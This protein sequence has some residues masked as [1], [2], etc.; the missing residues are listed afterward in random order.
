MGRA[1][2]GGYHGRSP[3][4]KRRPRIGMMPPG[5]RKQIDDSLDK[6]FKTKPLKKP[7]FNPFR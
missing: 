7:L 4:K 1:S 5:R 3:Y 2:P 6:I